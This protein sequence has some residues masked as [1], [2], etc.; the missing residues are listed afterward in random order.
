MSIL[1]GLQL[2]ISSSLTKLQMKVNWLILNIDNS[3]SRITCQP[4]MVFIF[5]KSLMLNL[6]FNFCLIQSRTLQYF[7]AN[8]KSLMYTLT[9]VIFFSPSWQIRMLGLALRD[10]NSRLVKNVMIF[11][12]YKLPN[13]LSLQI[14]LNS[15][16]TSSTLIDQNV[17]FLRGS[18]R[19]I[20]RSLSP[21]KLSKYAQLIISICLTINLN[22]HEM[23]RNIHGDSHFTIGENVLLKSILCIYEKPCTM[24]FAL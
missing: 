12:F 11:W 23:I 10:I 13:Y 7:N 9:I 18:F 15:Q 17:F 5:P 2:R 24:S 6:S 3:Q 19:K 22:K 8:K 16:H 4:M 14:F 1:I 21:N 20:E